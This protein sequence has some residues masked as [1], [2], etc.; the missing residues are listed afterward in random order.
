MHTLTRTHSPHG[1]QVSITGPDAPPRRSWWSLG[2]GVGVGAA[3]LAPRELPFPGCCLSSLF[4]F[5]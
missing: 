1:R 2:A 4:S 3:S 5:V